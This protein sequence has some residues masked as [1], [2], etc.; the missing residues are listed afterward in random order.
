M[1]LNELQRIKQW[2]VDHRVEHPLEYHL[3]DLVLTLWLMG[4]LPAFVFGDAWAAPLCLAGTLL[5]SLYVAW[6]TRAHRL[7]RLRCDWLGK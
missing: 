5:P 1:T 7:H 2:H 4:W 3:W 6:R